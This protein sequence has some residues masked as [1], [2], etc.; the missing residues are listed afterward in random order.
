MIQSVRES[1]SAL[2]PPSVPPT[3]SLQWISLLCVCFAVTLRCGGRR[4]FT[5]RQHLLDCLRLNGRGCM[6]KQTFFSCLPHTCARALAM[7]ISGRRRAEMSCDRARINTLIVRIPPWGA[8]RVIGSSLSP[9]TTAGDSVSYF[10][11]QGSDSSEP[12]SNES[13]CDS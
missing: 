9:S 6:E 7:L 10:A 5:P 11:A 8:G 13:A 3:G 4:V 2:H 1:V 12:R